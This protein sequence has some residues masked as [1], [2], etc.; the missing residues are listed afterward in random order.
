MRRFTH[1]TLVSIGLISTL[2]IFLSPILPALASPLLVPSI[3]V[4]K[5]DAIIG[6]DG[7]GKA[8]PGE[9][10]EY[11]VTIPNVGTDATGVAFTD[12]IDANTTLVGGSLAVSPIAIN[13]S[14]TAT[15]N[16]SISIAAGSGVQAND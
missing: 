7:D 4:S 5:T 9:I 3:S 12:T 14:Y 15:R 16:L 6:D 13:E 8:D 2:I 1:T 11:T 10:I